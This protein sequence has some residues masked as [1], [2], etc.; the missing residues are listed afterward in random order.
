MIALLIIIFLQPGGDPLVL[1]FVDFVSPAHAATAMDA[2]QG[3]LTFSLS[4]VA[5]LEYW[6]YT[7]EF[8]MNL[9]SST[10]VISV[11]L[12][13]MWNCL[14]S[15]RLGIVLYDFSKREAA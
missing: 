11:L 8:Q 7:S 4:L 1:C 10:V 13:H 9:I 15:W 6:N 5:I 14:F 3:E 2:L 12:C